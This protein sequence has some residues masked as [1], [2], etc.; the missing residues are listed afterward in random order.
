MLLHMQAEV[1]E[2]QQ[3]LDQQVKGEKDLVVGELENGF[4]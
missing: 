3:L 2:V 1:D 4:R